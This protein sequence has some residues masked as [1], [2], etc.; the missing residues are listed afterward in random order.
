M[1]CNPAVSAVVAHQPVV[2]W[3]RM[4][5]FTG[6]D[7]NGIVRRNN[8][9]PCIDRFPPR[10]LFIQT[11]YC[12]QRVGQEWIT[13]LVDA[14]REAYAREGAPSRFTHNVMRIPGHDGARVPNS[15]LDAVV[16]WLR[17]QSLL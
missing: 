3:P 4:S 11:G 9:F 17:E 1:A 12:D 6:M 15:A 7:D 14:L 5:E 8:L 10:P 2:H 13:S 16:P